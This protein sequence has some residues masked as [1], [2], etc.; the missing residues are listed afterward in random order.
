MKN[1][2]GA[3][4]QLAKGCEKLSRYKPAYKN[5]RV[6]ELLNQVAEFMHILKQTSPDAKT[7]S[8]LV[9]KIPKL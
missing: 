7:Y 6:D 8:E 5:I 1:P 3:E 4:S 9:E 2:N